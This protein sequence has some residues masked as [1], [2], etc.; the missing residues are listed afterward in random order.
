MLEL[1]RRNFIKLSGSAALAV[2]L[3]PQL[4]FSDTGNS[5]SNRRLILLEMNGGNDGLNTVIPY[6]QG[7]YY[8][9]R[10]KLA[11][12]AQQVL[13]INNQIGLHPA[14]KQLHAR[15]QQNQ[16][17]I[18]QGVGHPKPDLSHFA[19]MDFWRAGH[20]NGMVATENT[21][22]LGRALDVMGQNQ[23]I[24]T[25]L[26]LTNGI[27]PA[28]FGKSAIVASLTSVDDYPYIPDQYQTTYWSLL[29]G[30]ADSGANDSRLLAASKKGMRH[31]RMAFDLMPYLK[32]GTKTYPDSETGRVFD[33]AARILGTSSE[34]RVLHIPLPM[35]FDTHSNQAVK[36][37]ANFTELDNA[38]AV[39]LD[40]LADRNLADQ[41]IILVVSE[42]GRRAAE[43]NSLGTD[44]G[45]ANNAF[46]IGSQVRGGLYGQQPSLADLDDDGNTKF[47][48]P[49]LDLLASVCDSWLGVDAGL[50]VPGGRALSLFS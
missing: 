25:G 34:L 43:N 42:F 5:I 22:W 39:L 40:D 14:L 37:A 13:P 41:T 32:P 30:L 36:Q 24:M 26:S 38:L 35:D 33:L 6:G 21:G 20:L 45:T 50:V 7:Q 10:P 28:L 27:G 19:M 2:L 12:P 16:V 9:L 46:V 1:S 15:F 4:G 49:Y 8:D 23:E 29:N 17:A 47:N 18:V 11:I 31:S 48:L 3:K 44:H